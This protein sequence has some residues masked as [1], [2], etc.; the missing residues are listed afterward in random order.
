MTEEVTKKKKSNRKTS[1]EYE[2]QRLNAY[3][4]NPPAPTEEEIKEAD[5]VD[6]EKFPNQV[7]SGKPI[8]DKSTGKIHKGYA[9]LKPFKKGVSG[10]PP[11]KAKG[12]LSYKNRLKRDLQVMQWM[13]QDPELAELIN[14]LDNKEMFDTLK[15][16]A[17]AT[18]VKDPSDPTL[19]DRAYKAVAEDREYT[20]GKKTRTEIDQ[21]VTKVTEMTIE[22]LEAELADVTDA[23]II[24]PHTDKED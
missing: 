16:T 10:N 22:Q 23:D 8:I 19:F 24:T 21:K 18:F 6:P 9:N 1:R 11:G 12:T 7:A 17:F 5:T 15:Q 13:Q 4:V 14:S 2:A 20:E 3:P